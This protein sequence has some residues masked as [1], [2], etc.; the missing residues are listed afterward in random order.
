[1]SKKSVGLDISDKAIEIVEIKKSGNRI[2]ISKLNHVKLEPG[3]LKNGIIENRN[4]L[5]KS[6]KDAFKKAKPKPIKIKN[7]IFGLPKKQVII[8]VLSID[9]YAK[10]EELILEAIQ[11]RTG[12]DKDEIMFSYNIIKEDG[13]NIEIL[14][15]AASKAYVLEWLKFF[16]D[17]N[18]RVK[19]FDIETLAIFRGLTRLKGEIICIVDINSSF[20]SIAI[21]DK[22]GL[23]QFSSIKIGADSFKDERKI[24][25]NLNKINKELKELT[26]DFQRKTNQT[27]GEIILV[28]ETERLENIID[29]FGSN[30][31]ANV[32]LGTSVLH[33]T[34]LP[35]DFIE[36][37]GLGIRGLR[38]KWRNDLFLPAKTTDKKNKGEKYSENTEKEKLLQTASYKLRNKKRKNIFVFIS[39]ILLIIISIA[40]AV[41]MVWYFK[42]YKP[43]HIE[44]PKTNQEQTELPEQAEEN[45]D[46]GADLNKVEE[47][48]EIT[49]V[50][51][52]D[53]ETGWLNVRQ[54]PG[55][56]YAI[57][58]KIYPGEKYPF[59][60]EKN[61]WYKIELKD[62][63]QGWIL[64][65][66]ATKI[67]VK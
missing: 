42:F 39:V 60:E 27:V 40:L 31:G 32:S 54:G 44:E 18:I 24:S 47:T 2:K 59:L 25:S 56:Q 35:S 48:E 36:A 43:K 51:I 66:Y 46:T 9:F 23:K 64:S 7:I 62:K 8:L 12:L 30:L 65:D 38:K 10:K 13:D 52:K 41:S 63:T 49:M 14:V 21:F 45:I 55:K 11:E 58:V 61:N 34:G 4:E 26:N 53:T 57:L 5:K 16:K 1:M 50:L 20:S 3:V 28:G 33:G 67:V 37:I 22:N 19:F 17:S 29:Y 15:A 6:L